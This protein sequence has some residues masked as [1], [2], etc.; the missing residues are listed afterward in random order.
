MV[1]NRSTIKHLI[2]NLGI[3]EIDCFAAAFIGLFYP[4]G[5][6]SVRLLPSPFYCLL[7]PPAAIAVMLLYLI[8]TYVNCLYEGRNLSVNWVA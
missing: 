8:L 3:S 4:K 2:P 7:L 1:R 6:C 5:L